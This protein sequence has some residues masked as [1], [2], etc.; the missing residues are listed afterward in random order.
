MEVLELGKDLVRL[1]PS[2]QQE[3][4]RAV[5]PQALREL[6]NEVVADIEIQEAA[7][8][9]AGTGPHCTAGAYLK[10]E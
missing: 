4:C 7:G 8:K 2:D 3:Q 10:D 1:H 5:G 6:A 9:G